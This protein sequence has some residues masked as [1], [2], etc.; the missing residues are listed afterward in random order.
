MKF[1]WDPKKA[2]ANLKKHGVSFQ[3]AATVFGDPLAITFQDPDHSEV[4]ERQMTF[5][6]SLQKRLVVVSHTER[7]EQTRI[8]SARLMDSKERVIYEEG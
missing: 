2:T 4:E 5:G 6:Q 1:E 3:E 8:I 7:K